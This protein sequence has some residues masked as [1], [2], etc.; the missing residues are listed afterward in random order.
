MDYQ[1]QFRNLIDLMSERNWNFCL[2]IKPVDFY[3][4]K[5]TAIWVGILGYIGSLIIIIIR[6]AITLSNNDDD[7]NNDDCFTAT[8]VH[9]VG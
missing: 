9:I 7:D 6:L 1:F 4:V 8:F 5:S 2:E 3:L